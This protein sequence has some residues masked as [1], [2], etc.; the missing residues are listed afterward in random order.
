MKKPRQVLSLLM[1]LVM[2]SPVG[3]KTSET[4]KKKTKK[5][6]VSSS[7]TDTQPTEPVE[8]SAEP[9]ETEG[10]PPKFSVKSDWSQYTPP[11]D[12]TPV[13][14]RLSEGP[15]MEFTPSQDYGTVFP[16]QEVVVDGCD[17][18]ASYRFGLV[19]ENGCI[20]LDAIANNVYYTDHGY[21][22]EQYI[23][24]GGSPAGTKVGFVS[25]DGTIYSGMSY[26]TFYSDSQT[27]QFC[28]I[29]QNESGITVTPYDQTT[30]KAGASYDLKALHGVYNDSFSIED[31]LYFSQILNHRFIVLDV[32]LNAEII[33]GTTGES[34]RIGSNESDEHYYNVSYGTA[35][36]FIYTRE[37]IDSCEIYRI[38]REDKQPLFDQDFLHIEDLPNGNILLC[39]K[40]QNMVID[41]DGKIIAK[42]AANNDDAYATCVFGSYILSHQQDSMI[43][44]DQD[45][46]MCFSFPW[47][48]DDYVFDAEGYFRPTFNCSHDS[49][50]VIHHAST[51]SSELVN[52]RTQATYSFS[53]YDFEI[54]I[55][56]ESLL[57]QFGGWVYSEEDPSWVLLKNSDLHEITKADGYA[58]PCYDS[59]NQICY[60]ATKDP[61]GES[62][63]IQLLYATGELCAEVD[64]ISDGTYNEE[65]IEVCGNKIFRVLS[66]PREYGSNVDHAVIMTDQDGNTIFRYNILDAESI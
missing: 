15:I 3:C 21:I 2:L 62:G 17:Q 13:Y 39:S 27:D 19:D 57:I 44:Y 31:L 35:G 9:S 52:L 30:G 6:K 58:T 11:L 1:I 4:T 16:F 43:V 38:Y 7:V 46:N 53:A 36:S 61:L 29:T 45:L 10:P 60:L 55:F 8:T 23:G 65:I 18:N 41:S 42:V 40:D 5:R 34:F 22:L 49:L 47:S 32:E 14:T 59:P 25:F 56:P 64:C 12:L 63:K 54:S 48:P 26:H 51:G 33:D 66:L 24:G 20:V 28:F 37:Y 50:V